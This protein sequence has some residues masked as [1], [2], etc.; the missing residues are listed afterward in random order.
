MADYRTSGVVV[1]SI[2]AEYWT[3]ALRIYCVYAYTQLGTLIG[4]VHRFGTCTI[5]KERSWAL[6]SII[7]LAWQGRRSI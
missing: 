4:T 5:R 7:I 2:I 6:S 3:V 1:G